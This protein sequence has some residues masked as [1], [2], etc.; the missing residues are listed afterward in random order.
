MAVSSTA[1]KKKEEKKSFGTTQPS[2]EENANLIKALC[3][4]K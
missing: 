4:K 1:K 3:A 2:V